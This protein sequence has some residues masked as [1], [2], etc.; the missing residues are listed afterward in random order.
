MQTAKLE[1]VA[2][3]IVFWAPERVQKIK[4]KKDF[5]GELEAFANGLIIFEK[6]LIF[7][8]LSQ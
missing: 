8:H 5:G 4:G 6:K 1:S 7:N 2:K 3:K